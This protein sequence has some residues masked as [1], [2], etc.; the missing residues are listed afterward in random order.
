MKVNSMIPALSLIIIFGTGFNSTASEYDLA[1]APGVTTTNLYRANIENHAD[2]LALSAIECDALMKVKN[3]FL[4]LATPDQEKRLAE[5]GLQYRLIVAGVDRQNL[6]LD[7]RNEPEVAGFYPVVFDENGIR[8]IRFEWDKG[9]VTNRETGLTPILTHNL[10]FFYREPLGFDKSKAA[11]PIVLDSLIS[12][13]EEDSCRSYTEQ[14][15]AFNGRLSGTGSNYASR[16]WLADKFEDFGYDSVVIDGFQA[17]V[18]GSNKQCYNVLAYKIGTLYQEDHIIIGAHFDAEKG[19]PG[20]DDNASGTAGVL[21]IA[22][23][24]QNV[25]TN[26]TMVFAMFDAEEGDY[27]GSQHYVNR[28]FVVQE[29]IVFMLCLDMIAYMENDSLARLHCGDNDTIGILWEEMGDSL[30]GVGLTGVLGEHFGSDQVSFMA[31]GYDVLGITEWIPTPYYHEPQDSTTY[32]EFDYTR[33][34]VQASLAT[35]Y[36]ADGTYIPEPEVMVRFPNGTPRLF[37]PEIPPTFEVSVKTYGGAELVPGSVQLH[38]SVNSGAPISSEMTDLGNDLYGHTLSPLDCYNEVVYYISAEESST[39]IHYFPDPDTGI[40]AFTGT[41]LDTIIYDNFDR[42][43]G[44]TT[45]GDATEGHW[46][47]FWPYTNA[48]GSPDVNYEMGNGFCYQTGGYRGVDVDDGMA[49]LISPSFDLSGGEAFLQYARWYTNHLMTPHPPTDIFEIYISNDDGLSWVSLETIGP[50][51][52]VAGWTLC[53]FWISGIIE[54]TD[55]VRLRFDAS[56]YGTDSNI[57]AGLDAFLIIMR[58]YGPLI[59]TQELPYWNVGLPYWQQLTA[60]GC[61][62]EI[63][64]VDKYGHLEGSGL[65]LSSDGILSGIPDETGL[66]LFTAVATDEMDR[67]DEH[68]YSFN[69]NPVLSITTQTLPTGITNNAYTYQLHS[70]GGTGT[71]V[72]RDKNDDLSIIGFSLT[73]GGLLQGI[74][75]DTITTNFVAQI[76][77]DI[78]ALDEAEFTLKI[79]PPYSCGDANS[80]QT[81]NVGD[82]VF[83]IAYVFTGGPSPE[84]EEAG[85]ANCDGQVNVGDAVYLIAYVFSGG[86]EPCCP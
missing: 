33:R 11:D 31:F 56:D 23:V 29:R 84:P 13:V 49:T 53:N 7:M 80:D 51:N 43:L 1:P 40:Q 63:T 75:S 64:W 18:D 6:A 73:S 35:V 61:T 39:G 41:G 77:D 68:L 2:A 82:A 16:D 38:Y 3:G 83:L 4:L 24:L 32:L 21:E 65:V 69:V 59:L 55:K 20:A 46:E 78:G 12:Q 45:S 48:W 27:R 42:D 79:R 85:D 60:V 10:Q 28:A 14:L 72:W 54:P 66:I 26:A 57:E 71:K 22:R 25:E 50:E 74:T 30:P 19:S 17:Y 76:E 34:I 52:A 67:S 36:E 70:T 81:I 62:D 44:W 5:T 86:A 47:R 37:L 9:D 15:E 58:S 8:L